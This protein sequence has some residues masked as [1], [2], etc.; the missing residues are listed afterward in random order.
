MKDSQMSH[1]SYRKPKIVVFDLGN[2]CI[3]WDRRRGY[4]EHFKDRPQDVDFF[5]DHVCSWNWIDRMDRGETYAETSKELVAQHPKYR[6]EIEAWPQEWFKMFTGEITGTVQMIRE[7]KQRGEVGLWVLS[8]WSAETFPWAEKTFPFLSLFDGKVISGREGVGKP[9]H[10]IYHILFDRACVAPED[11]Y[12]ADDRAMN[13]AAGTYL[14][15]PG[16][17]FENPQRLRMQFQTMGLLAPQ[18]A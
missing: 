2:V 7:L 3:G 12:F 17:V 5:F 15:M 18:A 13:I 10:A 4:Q 1:I 14:G 9:D 6:A 16:H 8:N 11:A